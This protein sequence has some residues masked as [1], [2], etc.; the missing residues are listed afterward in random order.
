MSRVSFLDTDISG[1][2]FSN[3]AIWGGKD[4]YKIIEEEWFEKLCRDPASTS[5][6]VVS[7]QDILLLYRNL[8]ENYVLRRRYDEA[9]K[10]F[11]R[12]IELRRKY[13]PIHSIHDLAFPFEQKNWFERNFLSLLGWHHILSNY[14]NS[15]WRPIF[16]GMVIIFLCT[17][18]FVA[19]RDPYKEPFVYTLTKSNNN[20]DMDNNNNLTIASTL[21]RHNDLTYAAYSSFTFSG[22]GFY[23]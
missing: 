13:K 17:I 4:K 12:E 10:F 2:R 14:G 16:T 11:I 1:I 15:I 19:Q 8:R 22:C 3:K 9:D 18:F 21:Y 7:L 23:L 5:I 20:L 6:N